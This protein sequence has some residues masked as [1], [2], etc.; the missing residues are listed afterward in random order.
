ME[1]A[2]KFSHPSTEL[3]DCAAGSRSAT[4]VRG[5]PGKINCPSASEKVPWALPVHSVEATRGQD[6]T[7]S[8]TCSQPETHRNINLQSPRSCD[9]AFEFGLGSRV[10]NDDTK[11]GERREAR[12]AGIGVVSSDLRPAADSRTRPGPAT[13]IV[14]RGCRQEA[15][16]RAETHFPGEGSCL[17]A[18]PRVPGLRVTS[19]GDDGSSSWSCRCAS[20]IDVSVE[21]IRGMQD[22][23]NLGHAAGTKRTGGQSAEWIGLAAFRD[24]MWGRVISSR[25]RPGS[26]TGGSF[27]PR[28]G[29]ANTRPR[30]RP[31]SPLETRPHTCRPGASPGA[32]VFSTGANC[33]RT[34][35]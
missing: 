9:I 2:S 28:I 29:A 17:P 5:S 26:R 35:S 23:F 24:E 7:A 3:H 27:R 34:R 20:S 19:A 21:L 33:R 31:V 16:P 13:R 18:S 11:G 8:P 25:A 30:A 32:P 1:W 6:Y 4:P 22:P 12:P 14:P 10:V 15:V